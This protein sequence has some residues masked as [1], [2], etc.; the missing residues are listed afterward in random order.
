MGI[1]RQRLPQ[2]SLWV[3]LAATMPTPTGSIQGASVQRTSLHRL[4]ADAK[5][6]EC[7]Q[8]GLHSAFGRSTLVEAEGG[9]KKEES[10]QL[11]AL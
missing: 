2:A 3:S 9:P 7:S 8:T 6:R 10:G 11:A 5:K 4:E 1:W